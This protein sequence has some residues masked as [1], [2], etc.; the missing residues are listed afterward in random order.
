MPDVILKN[1]FK[2][3][4]KDVLAVESLNLLIKDKEFFAILGPS[5]CGKSSTLRMIAGLEEVTNGDIY[6][7]E[8]RVTKYCFPPKSKKNSSKR[9]W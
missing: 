9:N 6:F 4:G 8:T 5:G 7:G 2:R 1:I 3:Y